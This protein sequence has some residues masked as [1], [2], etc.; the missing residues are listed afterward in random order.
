M[1]GLRCF[2]TLFVRTEIG[3]EVVFHRLLEGQICASFPTRNGKEK[4][5][6]FSSSTVVEKYVITDALCR[7]VGCWIL[8]WVSNAVCQPFQSLLKY[9]RAFSLQNFSDHYFTFMIT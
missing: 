2:G 7:R 9:L 3:T 4:V 6:Y 5:I 8:N 1:M